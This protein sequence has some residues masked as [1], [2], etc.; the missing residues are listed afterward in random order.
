L[1]TCRW[2]VFNPATKPLLIVKGVGAPKAPTPVLATGA[3]EFKKIEPALSV[4][5]VPTIE[6]VAGSEPVRSITRSYV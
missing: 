1:F 2:I 6:A 5:K 4:P 3:L